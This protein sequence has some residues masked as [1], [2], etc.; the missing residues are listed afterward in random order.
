MYNFKLFVTRFPVAFQNST[1]CRTKLFECHIN[2]FDSLFI[3]SIYFEFLFIRIL[4][5]VNITSIKSG[6]E[7]LCQQHLF[8]NFKAERPTINTMC[9]LVHVVDSRIRFQNP[10]VCAVKVSS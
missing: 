10:S 7:L 8:I 6:Q 1:S 2:P 3:F 4:I 9:L 5:F